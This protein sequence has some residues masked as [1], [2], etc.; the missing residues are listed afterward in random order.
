MQEKR[1]GEDWVLLSGLL[2]EVVWLFHRMRY[3][4]EQ[5][6]G[7]GEY[8][9]GR[10]GILKSL[11]QGGMQTVPQ[12]ARARYVSRQY[13]QKLANGLVADGWAIW[14]E[15]P[16]HKRSKLLSLTQEGA[17]VL[18]GFLD[19]ER[20][21]FTAQELP[22]SQEELQQTLE[23]LRK[24]RGSFEGSAWLQEFLLRDD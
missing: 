15:N 16:A 9:A 8:S 7:Q 13:I 6:H 3:A 11:A 21:I 24:L 20:A 14:Q 12:L 18:A 22:V 2:D 5:V 10:R 19:K 23:T 4:A 17:Q 1:G